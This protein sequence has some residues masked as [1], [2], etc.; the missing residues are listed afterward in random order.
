MTK[1][2]SN[3]SLIIL[4]IVFTISWILSMSIMSL[5]SPSSPIPFSPISILTG[6]V[7]VSVYM[8]FMI[9]RLRIRDERAIQISDR[10]ARNGFG[11]VLYGIPILIIFLSV[12]GAVPETLLVLLLIW[13]G[14]VI[15]AGLSAF[16][17]YWK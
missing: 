2:V 16:Y 8:G 4:L 1:E 15:I 7:F 12:T 5:L 10:S 17:Y 13:F 3:K 6:V 9:Y 14:T 11:F